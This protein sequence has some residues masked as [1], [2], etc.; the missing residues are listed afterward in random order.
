MGVP[1]PRFSTVLPPSQIIAYATNAACFGCTPIMKTLRDLF[2]IP[3]HCIHHINCTQVYSP[4]FD[5]STGMGQWGVE[6]MLGVQCTHTHTHTQRH[7]KT[8]THT[9]KDTHSVA[10]VLYMARM[11]TNLTHLSC[12]HQ[13]ALSLPPPLLSLPPS[14][15]SL[16]AT[17][18]L[19]HCHHHHCH[20]HH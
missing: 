13:S 20:R 6:A 19:C 2:S 3:D 11:Q 14:A 9:H 15:L 8:Q 5:A 4:C 12:C 1:P 18:H 17:N 10:Q 16:V 7:T